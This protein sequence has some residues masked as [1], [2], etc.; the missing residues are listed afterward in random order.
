MSLPLISICVPIYNVT[1]YIERCVRSLMEQTYPNIE[2]VFVDDCSTDGSLDIL[3]QMLDSYPEHRSHVK[4]IQNDKNHGLAYTRRISIENASGEY[5]VCVDSDDY[6][7]RNMIQSL[8]DKAKEE[9]ADIVAAGYFI[10]TK[11]IKKVEPCPCQPATDYLLL[12]LSDYLTPIWCKLIRR[13][14]FAEGRN[15]FAP[16]GMDYME[17]RMTLLFLASKTTHIVSIN[18]ALYHYVFRGDSVSQGK[19]EKHFRCLIQYW[20]EADKLLKETN[21]TEKYRILVGTQKIADKAHLLMFCNNQSRKLFADLY[22]EEERM[23]KPKLSRGVA[24]MHWL[25]KHHLWELTY[26]YQCYIKW[27]E[28]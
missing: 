8:V 1:P 28:H 7:E 15:C 25:T 17:D 12:A 4:L 19:N 27:L 5:V 16:E 23:Y 18:N 13:S 10:E 22:A 6:V 3:K 24:L 11:N 21:M 9:D 20:K 26:C 14:L 2:Y